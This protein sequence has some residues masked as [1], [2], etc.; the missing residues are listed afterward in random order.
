[1]NSIVE[2][3]TYDARFVF[4]EDFQ[5][6]TLPTLKEYEPLESLVYSLSANSD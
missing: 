1:M 3:N 4:N 6:L 2:N 5:K